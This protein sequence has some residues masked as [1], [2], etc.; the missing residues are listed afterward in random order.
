VNRLSK[1]HVPGGGVL[2][3]NIMHFARALRAAG[4]PIGPGKTIEAVEAVAVVGLASRAD[5]YW[6]LHAVFV[7]R[8]AQ[9]EVFDQSFRLFWRNPEDLRRMMMAAPSN[10]SPK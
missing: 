1:E 5:F 9:R 10:E 8:A 6:A 4:L 7:E 2:A 3:L